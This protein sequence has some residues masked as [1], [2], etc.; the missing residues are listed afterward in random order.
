MMQL[1][2]S[3]EESLLVN[4]DSMDYN[5]SIWHLIETMVSGIKQFDK[6]KTEHALEKLNIQLAAV[7]EQSFIRAEEILYFLVLH[8]L[9]EMREVHMITIHEEEVIWKNMSAHIGVEGYIALIKEIIANSINSML[10]KKNSQLLMISAEDYIHRHLESNFG[11]EEIC[12]YLSI[13][14]S[15]FSLLFKQQYGETFVEYLS[16][17]RIERAKSMLVLSDKSITQIGNKVGFYERRYFTSVF[18]KY[19]GET[20]SEYR[21]KHK[22]N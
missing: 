11:I 10:K 13:S 17:Q 4:K 7:S 5:D 18:Q 22:Q 6:E 15:Y 2:P 12:H 20:P 21:D 16:K 19:T 14:P 3:K 9:R 8:L 1:S